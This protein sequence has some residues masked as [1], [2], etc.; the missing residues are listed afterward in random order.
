MLKNIVNFNPVEKMSDIMHQNRWY[1]STKTLKYTCDMVAFDPLKQWVFTNPVR[2]EAYCSV[3]NMIFKACGFIPSRCLKCW[4]VVVKPF[5]LKELMALY[6][7]QKEFT[8]NY[9]EKDRFCKCGVEPR[10]YV[11]Y[12]YGGYF[13]NR[14]KQQGLERYEQVRKAVDKINP[15]I[16][17]ILKRYCTEFEIKTGPSDQ[18]KRPKGSDILESRINDIIDFD[19]IGP[20]VVQPPDLVE[21]VLGEWIKFA[22]DRGDHTA[23]MFNDNEPLFTPSV[24][25]HK[26]QI[27][28]ESDDAKS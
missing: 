2:N 26:P 1:L 23:I 24:T 20:N 9:M 8:A 19:S 7:F 10:H 27:I 18:Y 11:H 4:K 15:H 28:K 13:Y 22:W 5:T 17:V 16:P 12:N 25:Y 3:Y 14:S 21:K 6:E